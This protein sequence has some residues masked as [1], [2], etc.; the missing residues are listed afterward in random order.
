MFKGTTMLFTES[1]ENDMEQQAF[2]VIKCYECKIMSIWTHGYSK[3]ISCSVRSKIR[4]KYCCDWMNFMQFPCL[5]NIII[6]L[7]GFKNQQI[8]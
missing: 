4:Y 8:I 6:S 1:Y 5:H 2:S 7:L 3:T